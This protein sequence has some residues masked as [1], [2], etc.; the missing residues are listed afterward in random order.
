[1]PILSG[2]TRSCLIPL[3]SSWHSYALAPVNKLVALKALVI[4]S[5]L[6][7]VSKKRDNH[8]QESQSQAA[9]VQGES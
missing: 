8:L 1:V 5:T 9:A 3:R 6:E 4:G 2:L 7:E